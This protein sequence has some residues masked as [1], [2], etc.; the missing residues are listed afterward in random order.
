MNAFFFKKKRAQNSKTQTCQKATC[1]F[2]LEPMLAAPAVQVVQFRLIR[3]MLGNCTSLMTQD[4]PCR[5]SHMP[6][7]DECALRANGLERMYLVQTQ[8]GIERR[9]CTNKCLG[10]CPVRDTFIAVSS[11]DATRVQPFDF[12]CSLFVYKDEAG[13]V[14]G[15]ICN[16]HQTQ[17]CFVLLNYHRVCVDTETISTVVVHV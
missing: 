6:V 3:P 2:C 12:E 15:C 11:P 17:P 13:G 1:L 16:K 4:N 7:S 8:C 10:L 14:V 5:V 9:E